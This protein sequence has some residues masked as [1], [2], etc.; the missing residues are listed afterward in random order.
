MALY[1]NDAGHQNTAIGANALYHNG[2]G[3]SNTAVGEYA[4]VNSQGG[5]YN[6]AIG[7]KAGYYVGTSSNNIHVGN[8][9][10]AGDKAVIRIGTQGTQS[11]T[12]IAGISGVPVSGTGVAVVVNSNGQLG[13][14]G[15]SERFKTAIAPMGTSTEKLEALKPVTF[16]Y[17]SDPRGERQYGLIAEEVAKIYPELVVRDGNGRILSIRY[18]ELAPMLLNE[19]KV[20]NERQRGVTLELAEEN[21]RLSQEV[22]AQAAELRE[23]KNTVATLLPPN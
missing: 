8:Y 7:F 3:N 11:A 4:L 21:R 18:E 2:N 6:V 16:Q 23:L 10:V 9:G 5:T 19:M 22:K 12:Y 1:L 20:L 14:Q 13:I 17:K 15:S